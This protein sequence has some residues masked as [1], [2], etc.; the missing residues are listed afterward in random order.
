MALWRYQVISNR[1]LEGVRRR[2]L[3]VEGGR[4]GGCER[5]TNGVTAAAGG[6]QRNVTGATSWRHQGVNIHNK[7]ATTRISPPCWRL[8]HLPADAD[9]LAHWQATLDNNSA[10]AR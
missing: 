6:R 3:R 4:R 5:L 9:I 7:H 10:A 2:P 8:R 1:A